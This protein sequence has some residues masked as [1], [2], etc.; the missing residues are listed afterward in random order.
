MINKPDNFLSMIRK[1]QRGKL[2]VYLGY[3]A[4][5]GKT[6]Q[7]LLEAHR[8]Q[9]AGVRVVV[10]NVETHGR[11]ETEALLAGLTI[12]PPRV[13]QYRN[14]T[15]SEMDV[16]AV[17]STEPEVVLVDELAH[18]NVP[19]SK[20]SKRYQDVEEILASGIHVITALNLQHLESLNDTLESVLKVKVRERVP[21]RIIIDAEQVV[22]VD[23]SIEDLITRLNEGKIYVPEGIENALEN[24]F[25]KDRLEQLRE[26]TLR[27][28]ASQIDF[29]R[30]VSI[31]DL[32]QNSTEQLMV[33]LSSQGP[34]SEKLLRYGSRMAGRLNRNWFAVYVQT[35]QDKPEVVR[36]STENVSEL[37]K[38]AQQLGATIFTY[39][40]DNV[41]DTILEFAHEYR[42][43]HILLGTPGHRTKFTD[44]LLRKKSILDSLIQQS[45]GIIITVVDTR[46]TNAKLT[47]GYNKHNKNKK[48]YNQDFDIQHPL[49]HSRVHIW[50]EFVNW[51]SAIQ[52]LIYIALEQLPGISFINLWEKLTARE[53][54]GATYFNDSIRFPHCRLEG[55]QH[56]TIVIG[57]ASAGVIDDS[58]NAILKLVILLISPIDDPGIHIKL[59]GYLSRLVNNEV[60]LSKLLQSKTSEELIQKL[61]LL[62]T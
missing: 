36:N 9:H 25:Q 32:P 60:V 1:S 2:K 57:L 10:G 22:N 35:S 5:V 12:I 11:L 15:I 26:M 7:M 62:E 61:E 23:V 49:K 21:D 43:G 50:K 16:D 37:L 55:I 47:Y 30:R 18:S 31:G 41:A 38:L 58:N 3:C 13:F 52:T 51:D 6:Y 19:G 20:N 17:F 42:I 54:Q 34:Q 44:Y 4:G 53:S 27:E 48:L 29:H 46:I 59:I 33:C 24:F 28:L 45:E 8:L 14:I 40:G 39:K 56:P